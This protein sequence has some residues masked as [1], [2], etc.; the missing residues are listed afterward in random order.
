MV[1]LRD[2]IMPLEF[3]TERRLYPIEPAASTLPARPRLEETALPDFTDSSPDE[4]FEARIRRQVVRPKTST[5]GAQCNLPEQEW[6]H[7]DKALCELGIS[8]GSATL[9]D[10]AERAAIVAAQCDA[11]VL[12]LGETGTGKE[13]FAKLIHRLSP[14]ATRE[15][16]CI[17][18]A[19]IPKELVES[20]LF[21]HVKGSFTG[22]S[23]NQ[24][25]KFESA[26]ESTL[27]LDEVGELSLSVQSKLLRFLQ[28][29]MIDPLGLPKAKKV[30]VRIVA[31]TNRNLKEEVASGKFRED[32]YYR[33]E[34]VDIRLPPLRKRV[35]EIPQ[36]AAT[37]LQ[38]INQSLQRPRTLTPA[39]IRRLESFAWP[40]NVR[41]LD[42]VLRRSAIFCKNGVIDESDL[43]LHD[44]PNGRD[45][46][47]SL[48]CPHQGF[49]LEDFLAVVKLRMVSRAIELSGGNQ[50]A[51]AQL[52]G[53]T[54]QGV[55]KIMKS[56]L[57]NKG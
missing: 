20:H 38:R 8:V 16:V 12:L 3:F 54:K 4:M 51:A 36:L 18:C 56:N 45:P 57:D 46:F 22:A 23:A 48:P 21:G 41:Q 50:T 7:L 28:D 32:L 43:E 2:L 31:A 55:S 25:G 30:D 40:G 1:G 10:A 14:R 9:R 44:S 11:P 29:G 15:M 42:N 49:V 26:H 37:L 39:A 5:R 53:M 27:F 33:L 34:V 24:I 35:T 17:N 47:D 19:A 13:L 52:L 6:S